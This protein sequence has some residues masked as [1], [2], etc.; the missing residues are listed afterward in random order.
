M[1]K[2]RAGSLIFFLAGIY[3]FIFSV[4]LPI[5]EWNQPGPAVFPLSLS[6]L[7]CISGA[8]RFIQEKGKGKIDW[9]GLIKKLAT[10][11][12]IVVFTASF[13]LAL[14]WLGFLVMSFL[15]LF[16]LFRWVSHYRLWA[17]MALSL[18]FGV[19]SWYFFGKVLAVQLPTGFGIL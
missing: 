16:M 12:Q 13:I 19:G 2:E 4:Q 9:G 10:P 11:L 18:I 6:L 3:G 14:D 15:Y 8:L 17:A 1:N 7:L 5:G